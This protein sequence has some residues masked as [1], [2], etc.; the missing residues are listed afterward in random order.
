MFQWEQRELVRTILS[1]WSCYIFSNER[2]IFEH[3][4]WTTGSNEKLW[5][6]EVT[7]GF[8]LHNV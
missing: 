3:S 1:V 6:S 2:F 7:S 8:T 4:G 5:T